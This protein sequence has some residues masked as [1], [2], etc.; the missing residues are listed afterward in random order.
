[1]KKES[2][3][4]IGLWIA[5]ILIACLL[6]FLVWN[7]TKNMNNSD[8]NSNSGSDNNGG[9]NLTELC[10]GDFYD[11]DDFPDKPNA[12]DAYNACL[13]LTGTDVHRLDLDGDGIVCE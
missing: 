8:N 1:M 12:Q 4:K 3:L 5:G 2:W 7:L 11:C 9:I 10:A 13:N 6:I